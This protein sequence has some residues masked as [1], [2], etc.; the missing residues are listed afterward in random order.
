MI[1]GPA[2]VAAGAD[3]ELL[4]QR[5]VG[6][7]DLDAQVAARHH[8]RVGDCDD[9][10]EVL[11]RLGLLDLGDDPR[12][13]PA[14]RRSARAA[15]R[16]RR[17]CARTR[18]RRSRRRSRAR[19]RGRT[20]S[21]SVR[22]GIGRYVPG[23]FTP[24]PDEIS[25]PTSTR[26]PHAPLHRRDPRPH[27]AVVDQHLAA[28]RDGLGD[29]RVGHLEIARGT[30]AGRGS[31]SV[32][33]G[34]PS[35]ARRAG[36]SGSSAPAGRRSPRAA[37][38]SGP[39]RAR[40]AGSARGASRGRRARSSAGRRPCRPRELLDHLRIG[41][42]RPDRAHDLGAARPVGRF[43][44]PTRAARR[45]PPGRGRARRAQ[46]LLDPQQLVVLGHAVACATGAPVLIWPQPVATARSA[47]V[48]SSVSPERCEMTLR[49][50]GGVRE[51]DRVERLR[52]RAD[53]VHLDQDGVG[54]AASMPR[55]SRS[56]LVTKRSSP[57]SW[58]RSPSRSVSSAPAVPVVLGQAVLDRHDR[59]AVDQV[60]V[61]VDHL[62]RRRACGPRRSGGSRRRGRARSPRGRA[63][64]RSRAAV[65]RRSRPPPGWPRSP[66][67]SSS[68]RARSRPR[69]R[70]GREAALVQ[71]RLQRVEDL[72]ADPQR[73]GERCPRPTGTTMNS[74]MST[75]L[76]A[77]APPLRTFIIGTGRM[78]APAPPR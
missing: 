32:S 12:V 76:S 8:H 70:R 20:Q 55:A 77:C 65:R 41:R 17:P 29:A 56:T 22:D 36:R 58:T 72:G 9:V 10:V 78:W 21:L 59:V 18:A 16:R 38:R 37:G 69:R 3:D 6:G 61:A 23:R 25:P 53:L 5:D 75:L 39:G 40:T 60:G 63:R 62:R 51:P 47:M 4:D 74:C 43:T 42:R 50:A 28:G 14:R 52:Q 26:V 44:A 1:T 7:A 71:E 66:P 46:L 15:S 30:L 67:R 31:T 48:V 2:G 13:R 73:L 35:A 54:D 19:T 68:G 27:Q 57:T 24:L 45:T 11:D 33:P 64:S 49:V 34:S